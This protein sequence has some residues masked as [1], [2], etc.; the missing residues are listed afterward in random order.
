MSFTFA[1][2][3]FLGAASAAVSY[4]TP[5]KVQDLAATSGASTA[6]A[7]TLSAPVAGNLLVA[8]VANR[9]NGSNA[10]YTPPA[11]FTLQGSATMTG[12]ALLYCYSKVA[13]GTETTNTFTP[14]ST[15]VNAGVIYELSGTDE[16]L[17]AISTNTTLAALPGTGTA[18]S[19]VVPPL[20]TP[21]PAMLLGAVGLNAASVFGSFSSVAL[22]PPNT[23]SRSAH[24]GFAAQAAAGSFGTT[25][26]WTTATRAS[27]VLV[28][29]RAKVI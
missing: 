6:L 15:G 8:F 24:A 9:G 22:T 18:T 3:A 17:D 25:A 4:Q 29:F 16:I 7:F 5:A 10:G 12:S 27:G 28:A 23:T 13:A 2:P 14:L 11:G 20:V 19:L 26:A 21:A 1:D